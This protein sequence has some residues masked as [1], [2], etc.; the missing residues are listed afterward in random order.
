MYKY[1]VKEKNYT[2]VGDSEQ[3]YGARMLWAKL[4][5]N[6]DLKVDIYN[7]KKNELLFTD[8]ILHHGKYDS[9]FDE[10]LWSYSK[11]KHNIRS[12]LIDIL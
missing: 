12:I 5:K 4:S 11:D 8:V 6:L 10:R 1:F 2:I 9:D 7:I 3:Y